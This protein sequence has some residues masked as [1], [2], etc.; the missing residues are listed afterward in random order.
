MIAE[1]LAH[2]A[3]FADIWYAHPGPS[4][5]RGRWHAG[6]WTGPDGDLL[7]VKHCDTDEETELYL[8]PSANTILGAILKAWWKQ[9]GLD[10]SCT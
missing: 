2:R 8:S 4:T 1:W 10:N 5:M 6:H 7:C 3:G 9:R